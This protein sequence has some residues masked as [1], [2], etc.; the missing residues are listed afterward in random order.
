[1]TVDLT[2][3]AVAGYLDRLA[4]AVQVLPEGRAHELTGE[5]RD[6]LTDA[7]SGV[8]PSDNAA[9][10][11]LLDRLGAPEDIVA[12]ELNQPAGELRGGRVGGAPTVALGAAAAYPG[13]APYPGP[14]GP[15]SASS[16]RRS[17][18]GV[19]EVLAVLLLTVGLVT[20]I[21]PLIGFILVWISQRWSV[22]EKVAATIVGSLPVFIVV[23]GL[24]A[25]FPV[26]AG[27]FTGPVTVVPAPVESA[28][29]VPGGSVPTQPT[30]SPSGLP[31][32]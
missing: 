32:P 23:I 4:R 10:L 20:L 15:G 1:M 22:R 2:H 26:R 5:I 6:H 28:E 30:S 17:P 8:D 16:G 14:V 21:G 31:T 18:W 7:L 9:V 27:S 19:T 25:F 12:A 24:L 11:D 13:T 29:S 3:P